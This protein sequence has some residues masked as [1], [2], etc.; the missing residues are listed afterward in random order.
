MEFTIKQAA[1]MIGLTPR[2]L[3]HYESLGLL[4][5]PE[6]SHGNYRLYSTADLVDLLRIKRWVGLGFSLAQIKEILNDPTSEASRQ[7]LD[8]L[9]A[10]LRRRQQEIEERREEIARIR[11]ARADLDVLPEY[12]ALLAQLREVNAL[13]FSDEARQKMRI[14]L[15]AALGS[16]EDKARVQAVMEEQVAL[17]DNPEHQALKDLD[18]RF[19]SVG[20]GSATTELDSLIEQYTEALSIV[21]ARQGGLP[22]TLGMDLNNIIYNEEQVYVMDA[23]MRSLRQ[24]L[25][26]PP[27]SANQDAWPSN[28]TLT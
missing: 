10:D 23:V 20:S 28:L 15:V 19:E 5:G 18:A 27:P 24:R 3:R 26:E 21:F 12:A 13:T 8:Q 4:I 16:E 2:A 6:R 17:A 1:D 14:E 22:S 7:M 25:T 9:D 11:S